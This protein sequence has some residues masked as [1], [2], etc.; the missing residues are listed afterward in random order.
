MKVSG[1]Y[2]N[3]CVANYNDPKLVECRE[4]V[5]MILGAITVTMMQAT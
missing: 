2:W 1:T 4:Q 5:D 3:T